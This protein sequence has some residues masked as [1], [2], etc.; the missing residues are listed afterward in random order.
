M[1]FC[2]T[3]TVN[4]MERPSA[5]LVQLETLLEATPKALT[6]HR[7]RQRLCTGMSMGMRMSEDFQQQSELTSWFYQGSARTFF[8]IGIGV[9]FQ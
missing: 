3:K 4:V 5:L 2:T 6:L 8:S 9:L 1:Q 7:L